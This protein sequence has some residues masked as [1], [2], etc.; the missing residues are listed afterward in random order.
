M[1]EE[2]GREGRREGKEGGGKEGRGREGRRG[3]ERRGREG[4]GV[5]EGG[6]EGGKEGG[7]GGRGGKEEGRREGRRG[8]GRE[9]GRAEAK[10]GPAQEAGASQ[11]R[12]RQ[13]V[14]AGAQPRPLV[15]PRPARGWPLLAP[16]AVPGRPVTNAAVTRQPARGEGG[17]AERSHAQRG[18]RSP[19]VRPLGAVSSG[20]GSGSSIAPEPRTEPRA[21]PSPDGGGRAVGD[22]EG[23]DTEGRGGQPPSLATTWRDGGAGSRARA[24]PDAS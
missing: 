10:S 9:G 20:G 11:R 16:M 7:R 23:G 21:A 18:R 24:L 1:E 19:H 22:A 17:A 8:E 14:Q 2:G 13:R 15:Q 5:K 4:E 3:R 12:G 6:R